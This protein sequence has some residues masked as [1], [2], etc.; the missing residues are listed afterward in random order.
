MLSDIDVLSLEESNKY[1]LQSGEQL[2]KMWL[3]KWDDETADCEQACGAG[4]STHIDF[5]SSDPQQK[6]LARY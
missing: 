4:G 1:I 5:P 3:F 2:S 6:H